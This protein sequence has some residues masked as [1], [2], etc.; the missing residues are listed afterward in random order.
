M[1]LFGWAAQKNNNPLWAVAIITTD[2]KILQNRYL[3]VC[4]V[5]AASPCLPRLLFAAAIIRTNEANKAGSM[6]R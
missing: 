1:A 2:I 4:Y 5:L 3:N 6:H